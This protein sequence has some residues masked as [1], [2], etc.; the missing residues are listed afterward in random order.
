MSDITRKKDYPLHYPEEILRIISAIAYDPKNVSVSGSSSLRSQQYAAD[1]DLYE[2]VK[3]TAKTQ[4]T[5]VKAFVRGFQANIKQLLHLPDC[6]VGDIKCGE[7]SEW[8]VIHGDVKN[9]RVVGY[10]ME[11]SK[12]RLLALKDERILTSAE[13]DEGLKLLK[14]SP[15]IPEFLEMSY[16]LR[17]HIVRWTVKDVLRGYTLLRNGRRFSLGE[18][19][20]TPAIAKVDAVAFVENSRFTDFSIIYRFHWKSK[21]LNNF[22]MDR[23]HEL[24]KNILTLYE[25]G[26]YYKMAKRIFSFEKDVNYKIVSELSDMFNGDLGRLYSLISDIKTLL[27]LIENEDTLPLE[28]IRY[29]ID[30]FRSRLASIYQT[31]GVG[32]KDILKRIIALESG[33][34]VE[35]ARGLER[36]EEDF[37]RVLNHQSAVVLRRL[38]LL[39]LPK[40]YKP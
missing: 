23:D 24:K 7:I 14:R 35:L 28:K 11:E 20:C 17:P 4:A 26:N 29:E 5:A 15:T 25:E 12:A 1:Y 3:S 33:D 10:D 19:F 22:K 39:P 8:K 40:K 37:T 34:R 31:K 18:A 13:V 2:D 38:R 36:L 6:Y 9:G 32:G 27:F 30:Q 21:V 16:V